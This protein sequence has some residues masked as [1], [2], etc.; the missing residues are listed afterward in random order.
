MGIIDVIL[1]PDNPDKHSLR[2]EPLVGELNEPAQLYPTADIEPIFLRPYPVQFAR[3]REFLFFVIVQVF[4]PLPEH[5]PRCSGFCGVVADIRCGQ[6]TMKYGVCISDLGDIISAWHRL[7][8]YVLR[9]DF[10][11]AG[12]FPFFGIVDILC[13]EFLPGQHSRLWNNC[14]RFALNQ[15]VLEIQRCRYAVIHD[16]VKML[17][18]INHRNGTYRPYTGGVYFRTIEAIFCL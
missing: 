8:V 14:Q 1:Y 7:P 5:V 18:G 17:A 4:H 12:S 16:V 10:K 13:L 2:L 9:D 15:T 11:P 6:H 3:E